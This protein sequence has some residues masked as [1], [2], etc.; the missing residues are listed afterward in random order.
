DS[1]PSSLSRDSRPLC[2]TVLTLRRPSIRI[3]SDIYLIHPSLPIVAI[4]RVSVSASCADW[5]LLIAETSRL[6]QYFEASVGFSVR[7]RAVIRLRQQTVAVVRRVFVR[8]NAILGPIFMPL[9]S[10]IFV[11]VMFQKELHVFSA[12]AA[13]H[14]DVAR[15]TRTH[16]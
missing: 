1:Q 11:R 15:G 4:L 16:H 10:P 12:V 13:K 5:T 8:R 3:V 6:S 9:P 14:F 2:Y 7:L